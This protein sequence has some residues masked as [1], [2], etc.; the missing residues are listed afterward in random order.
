VPRET[1]NTNEA[2]PLELRCGETLQHPTLRPPLLAAE[3]VCEISR[4]AVHGSFRRRFGETGSPLGDV[5]LPDISA[6]ERR[7]F[8]LVSIALFLVA[9]SLVKMIGKPHVFAMMEPRLAR[10]LKRSGLRF[11]PVGDI[12]DFRGLR[13]AYYIHVDEAIGGLNSDLTDLYRLITRSIQA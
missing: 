11:A 9:T 5:S 4:L 10:L 13:A 2:L 3:G 6:M 8:P 1:G 12:V 7:T